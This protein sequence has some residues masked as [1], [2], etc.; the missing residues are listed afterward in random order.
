MSKLSSQTVTDAPAAPSARASWSGLLRLS[1]VAVPVKAYPAVAT[2][3]SVH[4][5]QLHRDCDQRIGYQKHCPVHGRVEAAEI[6]KAFQYAPDQYVT[7]E[8]DELEKTRSAKDK[9]LNLEQFVEP[10]QIEPTRLSGRT[11][12]LLPHG[13]AAHRPYRVLAE[14]LQQRG[15]WALGRVSMSGH[16]YGVVVRADNSLLSMSMLHDP[17]QVRS[18]AGFRAQL[19]DEAASDEERNLATM[20]IDASSGPIDWSVYR[21]DAAAQLERLVEAK[22]AGREVIEPG[23]EPLQVLQ[24]MDALQKSV[25]AAQKSRRPKRAKPK[26]PARRRSA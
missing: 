10:E 9:A 7:I 14:A 11:L 25:D 3:E 19:R 4:L 22:V 21:D 12:Y 13:I 24:L 20:L 1:L 18:A 16:R 15:R 8:P 6:V 5:N 17:A 23:E 2:S 26:R